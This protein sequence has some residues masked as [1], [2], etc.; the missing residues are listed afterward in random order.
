[1]AVSVALIDSMTDYAGP[2]WRSWLP[3]VAAEWSALPAFLYTSNI[4]M[5]HYQGVSF[6]NRTSK[7]KVVKIFRGD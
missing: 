3:A 2:C 6:I 1:M 4:C 7:F 5:F